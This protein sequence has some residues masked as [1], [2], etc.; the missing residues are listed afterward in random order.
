[1]LEDPPCLKT[2]PHP[3]SHFDEA[4]LVS[5]FGLSLAETGKALEQEFEILASGRAATKQS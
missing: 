2:R 5:F 4:A 1:M 3:A